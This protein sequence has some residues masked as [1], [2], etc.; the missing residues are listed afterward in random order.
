MEIPAQGW[1]AVK[2]YTENGEVGTLRKAKQTKTEKVKNPGFA[3]IFSV[4]WDLA[5][6]IQLKDTV[7][8]EKMY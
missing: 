1:V 4:V 7:N 6:L 8:L 3:L 2:I 5:H